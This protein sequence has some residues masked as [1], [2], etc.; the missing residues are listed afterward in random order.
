MKDLFSFNKKLQKLEFIVTFHE[1]IME[2]Q[3]REHNIDRLVTVSVKE[4]QHIDCNY[5]KQLVY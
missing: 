3:A 4:K 2:F 5:T 1:Q